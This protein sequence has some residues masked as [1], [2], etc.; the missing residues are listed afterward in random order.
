MGIFR[1][2]TTYNRADKI[3][4]FTVTTAEYGSA[5]PEVFGTTRRSGNVIYYDD[6]TAH[7]HRES[8]KAGKGGRKK[9]VTISYTYT[10]ATIL[11]L[12]EGPIN[13]IGKVW[14]GKSVYDYPNDNIGLTCW[15]GT[16]TQQPWAYVQG[17]H[18]DKALPYKGLAYMAGVVD[19]GDNAT[20]PTYNFEIKGKLLSTGDYT[21]ANPADVIR[22]ILDKTGLSG[23]AIDG[24][25]NY[26]T[27]CRENDLLISSPMD[28]TTARETREIIN[29]IINLTNA[30]MFWSNDHYKIVV[31][32]DQ[33]HGGWKPDTTIRYALT[34]D[35]LL[36]QSGAALV[37]YSRKDSSEVYN[38]YP[39]EFISRKNS[40]DKETVSYA[41]SKDI[42]EHGVRQ[43]S[44][45]KAHW[46]YTKERAV[47]LAEALARKAIYGRN[48]YTFKLDWAFCRLEVGDLVTLTDPSIGL[49][50]Q[51]VRISSVTEGTNGVL[52]FTAVSV[53][54]M[55]VTAPQYDVHSQDR[56][57]V[58]YN[59]TAPD[60]DTPVLIQPPAD[61]TTNGLELWIGAKGKG[62]LWGG[63]EVYASDD[64]TTYRSIGMITNSA[65]IGTLATDVTKDAT[66]LEVS[67]NG[68]FLSGT[69][70]D[71]ER[72][73]TLCWVD[74]ECFSYQTATLLSNGDWQL[75]GCIRGQYFT[76][77]SDHK[78]GVQFAR[79]DS[80][81]LKAPFTK[82]DIGKKIWLKFVSYNI[83]GAGNQDLSKVKAYQY[84]IQPYYIPPVTGIS[85]Y[86]RYRQ[87]ADGVSRYDIVV[88]WTPPAL[89]S[90][91]EG[92]VWYKTDHGQVDN[93]AAAEGV[94]VDSMGFS[95]D[96]IF[97]GSG[98]DQVV[99]P[100]AVV[101]DTY[102]ICVTTV[103][104]WGAST[105]PDLAPSKDIVVA[106][107][108]YIPNTPDG[109]TVDFGAAAVASWKE[110]TNTD[111]S[112]YEIRLDNHPGIEGPS[113]LART[114]GLKASLALTSRTGTLY[115]YACNALGKYS[116][117]AVLK[118]SKA[119][120]PTPAVPK[121]TATIGGFGIMA[122]AIPN[123]CI[124][125]AI[126]IDSQD[127]IRTPNNV[128][129]CTCGAGVYA[130]RLAYYDLFGEGGKSDEA[131][132]T[133]KVEIDES[134]I[135]NEAISLDKVN[136][137]IKEQLSKGV[138]AEKKVSI[139]V[140]NLNAKD[141]YK[142]YSSLTQ[143]NDAINLRVKEGDVIN[144]INVSPESILIDGSKVHITGET[145]F[146][147][148]IVTSKML[149]AKAVTADKMSVDSLSAITANVGSLKG[150]TITGTQIVGTNFKNSS[151]SFTVDDAGNIYGAT[152]KSGTIDGNTIRINGYNVRAVTIMRGVLW[153][154]DDVNNGCV[155]V[156]LP[157]GYTESQCI[158]DC[159][160]QGGVK[161]DNHW[162]YWKQP[163]QVLSTTDTNSFS[164][165]DTLKK[166]YGSRTYYC[167][168]SMSDHWV[169]YWIIGVK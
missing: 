54:P 7:E 23:V 45:T 61:L 9:T 99:I 68:D 111:I 93:L 21:D 31:L 160:T 12:C 103:D 150:G 75:S 52:T 18:P 35:D 110:V 25:D 49:D 132:V 58:D 157:A 48:Q 82:S 133:V 154:D 84:T 65:R 114:N 20:F 162:S 167:D 6:F 44:T 166:A 73:N 125:M 158:W 55:D 100:Q 168:N 115:L 134:M 144:Q 121:L 91:L 155:T 69:A 117:P 81:L 108:T 120:P 27:Y 151:G 3:S 40:Y 86:N 59:V 98:K 94:S 152:L 4:N 79:M 34:P 159:Y 107:K 161:S 169:A 88:K 156:P 95:G 26:R 39:V 37:T 116:D 165:N 76:T 153:A 113:L 33:A 43:A 130:V 147:D 41:L 24:L 138:D 89:D 11:G 50:K 124:G 60:T 53:P 15:T 127:V 146:D 51:V 139:V 118:Y 136:A 42:A 112:Y 141:G 85:C 126:Y 149:Q 32:D 74:G 101:G 135:K 140:D 148:N 63:C 71:A 83:F 128:Y 122:K 145:Y 1:S 119:L 123:G 57:Y 14:V 67:S 8:H 109:F 2:H 16:D 13:G 163:Y 22:Y 38:Q 36:P 137:A 102:R 131:L 10:V 96:W 90:Y 62:D 64:G 78:A 129:S 142:N 46:F 105:S 80:T 47:K 56:P 72:G 97:G 164:N 29:E 70:Q 106:L 143:L 87:Q 19:L 77:A 5:V 66:T 28:D 17:K 30:Y 104:E 92:R